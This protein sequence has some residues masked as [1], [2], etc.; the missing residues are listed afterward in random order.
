MTA[1]LVV[2][3]S[4]V[5][6]VVLVAA[7]LCR[8]ALPLHVVS[9]IVFKDAGEGHRRQHAHHRSQSQHQTH[10]YAGKIYSTDGIQGH[11]CEESRER[12]RGR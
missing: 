10:H 11:W 5:L 8:R 2:E 7:V 1:N 6:P 9:Q 12:E 4:S 3:V